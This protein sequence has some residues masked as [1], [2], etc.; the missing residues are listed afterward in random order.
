MADTVLGIVRGGPVPCWHPPA[1]G[2]R[3]FHRWEPLTTPAHHLTVHLAVDKGSEVLDI[4]PDRHVD[5]DPGTAG[6]VPGER[7]DRGG[8]ALLGLQ[9]PP[10]PGALS[11]TA[12]TGSSAAMKSA[13]S[14]SVS[15]TASRA[16]LTCASSH[17]MFASVP[18]GILT[19]RPISGLAAATTIG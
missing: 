3:L 14:G 12:L 8:V 19:V 6:G 7:V 10:N 17:S 9:P 2:V 16:T 4:A 1:C 5:D 18:D 15:G 13:S 11:A